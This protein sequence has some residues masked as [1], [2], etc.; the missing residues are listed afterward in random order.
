MT[1]NSLSALLGR[2]LAPPPLG[3]FDGLNG[4]D[5]EFGGDLA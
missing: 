1:Y 2:V 4:E 5:F 3:S